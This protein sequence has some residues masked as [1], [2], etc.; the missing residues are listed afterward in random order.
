MWPPCPYYVNIPKRKGNQYILFTKNDHRDHGA[1]AR[2]LA[3]SVCTQMIAWLQKLPQGSL[4]DKRHW[5]HKS[6][7]DSHVAEEFTVFLDLNPPDV[8]TDH[9]SG[10]LDREQAYFV[11]Q[12]FRELIAL[13][14]AM[15]GKFEKDAI[16][17]WKNA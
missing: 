4:I 10:Y 11:F 16:W 3:L 5:E 15:V 8:H 2:I 9:D 14:G 13:Y 6:Y 7:G 17:G 1:R 12:E